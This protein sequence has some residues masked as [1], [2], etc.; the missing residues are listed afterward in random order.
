[1]QSGTPSSTFRCVLFLVS[2][3]IAPCEMHLAKLIMLGAI[4]WVFQVFGAFSGPKPSPE[5]TDITPQGV[6]GVLGVSLVVSFSKI[7]ES[8]IQVANISCKLLNL[9]NVNAA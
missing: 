3:V 1:M 7:V 8:T 9:T 4:A 6:L 2:F 5:L